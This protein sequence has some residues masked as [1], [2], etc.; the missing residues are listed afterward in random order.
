M[1]MYAY[2][3]NPYPCNKNQM[4]YKVMIHELPGTGVY[5]YYYTAR[6]AVCST[7]DSYSETVEIA[8]KELEGA[9]DE[10]GWI[11]IDDL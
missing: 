1:R 3:K 2:L 4:I 5:T 7:Y 9:I 10:Q 8:M 6:D 11:I